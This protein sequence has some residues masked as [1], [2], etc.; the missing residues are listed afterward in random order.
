MKKSNKLIMGLLASLVLSACDFLPLFSSSSE[1]SSGQDK[2]TSST[3][4]S[5]SVSSSS[6]SES[7]ASSASSSST[8]ST[9][10]SATSG[11]DISASEETSKYNY[12]DVNASAEATVFPSKGNRKI[13]VLPIT[14]KGYETNASST[15]KTNIEKN[16]FGQ[17]SDTGWESL[18]SYYTKSSYGQLSISGTVADWY[19][20]GLTA[21]QIVAANDGYESKVATIINAAVSSY[22]TKNSTDGK[23][24]DSDGDGY[25]DSVM[26]IF[27]CPNCSQ[28]VWEGTTVDYYND[29]NTTFWAF[30][31][32]AYSSTGYN[33]N[34]P[35][36]T[37]PTLSK[38][39]WASYDFMFE[40]YGSSKLD[41]HTFIHESGHLMGLDD[42]YDYGDDNGNASSP[43][44]S[45][46]MMDANVI[47]HNA[48]SKFTL[49]WVEPYVVTGT[50]GTLTLTLAPSA[51]EGSHN[52]VIFPTAQ[53]WNGSAFD[54]YIMMEY[55]TPTGLNQKDSQAGGYP[56]NSV[57]GFTENG[58]RVYHVDARLITQVYSNGNWNNGS[59][60]STIVTN[61]TTATIV[62]ASNTAEYSTINSSFKLLTAIDHKGRKFSTNFSSSQTPFVADNDTLFQNGDVFSFSAFA[63]QFPLST[64]NNGTAFGYRVAFSNLSAS[65]VTLTVTAA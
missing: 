4:T 18:A 46:D 51:T 26:A 24:F 55:Y 38:Y 27:S 9:S 19:A 59:V 29:D 44:G 25:I 42:Y 57:Q 35:S 54:E 33:L 3:S 5:L 21:A 39:F 37:S 16:L 13:L 63:S 41:A 40:G 14:I 36:A 12:A 17:A 8:S 28:S 11:G 47:D 31:Y 1:Q 43:M 10:S 22:K 62:A 32:D 7:T 61:A 6:V 15:N 53:G 65:G 30:T 60:T 49:G 45:V 23:D 56:G 50:S 64:M 52:C 48:F 34:N 2:S 20:C 58:V